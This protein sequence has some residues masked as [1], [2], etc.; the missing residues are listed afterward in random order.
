MLFLE[1]LTIVIDNRQELCP[2][3]VG[4][5]RRKVVCVV[6]TSRNVA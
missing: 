3:T 2:L 5:K 4:E 1:A 6:A